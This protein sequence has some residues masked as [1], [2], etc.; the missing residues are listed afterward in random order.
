MSRPDGE[1]VVRAIADA[2]RKRCEE[3]AWRKFNARDRST[4]PDVGEQVLVTS[5]GRMFVARFCREAEVW[6]STDARYGITRRSDTHWR[7]LPAGPVQE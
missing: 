3:A 6:E 1:V 7:P 4:W 5:Q 2:Y